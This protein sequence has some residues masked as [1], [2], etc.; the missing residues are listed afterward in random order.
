[1]SEIKDNELLELV[2]SSGYPLQIGIENAV[3]QSFQTHKWSI[4]G[5]EHFWKSPELKRE[6]FIDLVLSRSHL[7]LAVECKRILD[8]D[9]IFLVFDQNK[10]QVKN[11]KLLWTNITPSN[12]TYEWSDFDLLP[13]TCESPFC[14]MGKEKDRPSL[15]NLSSDLLMSLENLAKEEISIMHSNKLESPIKIGYIPVVVTTADLHICVFDPGDVNIDDGKVLPTS[16]FEKV[17]LIR[18]RKGLSTA[19]LENLYTISDLKG[20][21]KANERTVYIIHA[22]KFVDFLNKFDDA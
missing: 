3:K 20:S 16:K 6:G 4:V 5:R 9:W 18:F 2:N 21:N 13:D 19:N 22:S 12:S 10:I 8:K 11:S 7:R 17:D 15:E 14:I 1:M